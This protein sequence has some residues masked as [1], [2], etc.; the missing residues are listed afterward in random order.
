MDKVLMKKLP[1]TNKKFFSND[2]VQDDIDNEHVVKAATESKS[3]GTVVPCY[4][5]VNSKPSVVDD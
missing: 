4:P 1:S 5:T 3:Q 2:E